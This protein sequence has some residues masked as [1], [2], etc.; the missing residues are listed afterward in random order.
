MS[1]GGLATDEQLDLVP[2]L[3]PQR[4]CPGFQVEPQHRLGV[5]RSNIAP[6]V[7]EP[8]RNAVEPRHLGTGK[9]TFESPQTSVL[10]ATTK[11][12]SPVAK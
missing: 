11:F 10:S 2:H 3:V 6:P 4:L 8:N 9:R 5:A 12:S 1:F 7:G